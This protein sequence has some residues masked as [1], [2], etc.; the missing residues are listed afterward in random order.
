MPMEAV[1]AVLKDN[2]AKSGGRRYCLRLIHVLM[3]SG[4]RMS[5]ASFDSSA[6]NCMN[7]C[8]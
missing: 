5:R 7:S 1:A 2:L 8:N 6:T 3:I 4:F